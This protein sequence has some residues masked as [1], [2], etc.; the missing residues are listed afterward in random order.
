MDVTVINRFASHLPANDTHP[1]R[2]GPWRPNTVEY[3]ASDLLVQGE[4]PQG[5][6]GVY[7]RNTENPLFDARTKRYHPFDGD[8]MVHALLLESGCASYRNRFV[9]TQGLQAEIE[10]SG[11]LWAGI[12]E[13]PSQS[14][15]PGWGA[16]GAMKDASSTDILVHA[17]AAL[18]TFYQ[19][20]DAYRLDP[21]TL[22]TLGPATWQGGFPKPWGIAAHPKVDPATG[23][24]LYFNFGTSAPYM[25]CGEVSADGTVL[26]HTAV[27]LPG[28]RLPHDMAFTKNYMVLVDCPLFWD[29]EA[30][31][32]NI[33][34]PRMH[35]LPTRFAIV[36]RFGVNA[37]IRWFEA[38]STYILHFA[39]AYEQGDEIILD[40]F[41]QGCPIPPRML[42]D[43]P[44][45][46]VLRML[47]LHQLQ[48]RLHRWRFNLVT[49]VTCESVLDDGIA[50]FPS[51]HPQVGGRQ[52]RYVYAMLGEPGW[53]LFNGLVKYD[54]RQGTQE[55]YMFEPHVYAS[56][57][58]LAPSPTGG[59]EDDGYLL[60]YTI[61]MRRDLSECWIFDAKNIVRGPVARIRLPERICSGTHACWYPTT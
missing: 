38:S 60:T 4:I 2:T 48:A 32:K 3:N 39:N 59:E 24:L 46:S 58:P 12:L 31:A 19:C 26:H 33:Y 40:G 50:E 22:E 49:G 53:F 29:P 25:H 55:R 21:R 36:P 17:D 14:A 15:R 52:H 9:R 5:L 6:S 10:A 27:P 18:T 37:P 8:G 42:N 13:D 20:G 57:A 47:D 56:E 41:H 61:D 11:P 54:L 7:L 43:P 28:P 51:M 35:A 1:Y 30:L 34:R 16:R 44:F 45:A 23:R